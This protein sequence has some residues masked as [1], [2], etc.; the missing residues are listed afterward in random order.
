MATILIEPASNLVHPPGD[1]TIS[2]EINIENPD[3]SD[4]T[5][6]AAVEESSREETNGDSG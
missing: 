6:L 5:R 1:S 3:R 2:Q 4:G